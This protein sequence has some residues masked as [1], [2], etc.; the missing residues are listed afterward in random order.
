MLIQNAV[1]RADPYIAALQAA[2]II[3]TQKKQ[4]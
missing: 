4:I 1:C 3:L 2:D